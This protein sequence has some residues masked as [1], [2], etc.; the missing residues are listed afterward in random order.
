MA[1]IHSMTRQ[2]S[3]TSWRRLGSTTFMYRSTTI[4]RT[5]PI[6]ESRDWKQPST[7][8]LGMERSPIKE[9]AHSVKKRCAV[10]ASGGIA[11]LADAKGASS[12]P[13][14]TSWQSG[15]LFWSILNGSPR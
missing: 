11:S 6:R 5:L 1:D 3:A 14:L 10:V 15:A 13:A 12:G 2:P 4:V 7:G 9:I 8:T